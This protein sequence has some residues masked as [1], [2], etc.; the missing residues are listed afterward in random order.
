[1][2]GD[3]HLEKVKPAYIYFVSSSLKYGVGP[4]GRVMA[5][6]VVPCQCIQV[7][8]Q[9]GE[10]SLSLFTQLPDVYPLPAA[11]PAI[12]PT[13][14]PFPFFLRIYSAPG[15]TPTS[16]PQRSYVAF[17]ALGNVVIS[18]FGG[19]C[20]SDARSAFSSSLNEQLALY[21]CV[22]LSSASTQADPPPLWHYGKWKAGILS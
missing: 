6:E 4:L 13:S 5:S 19:V 15:H 16:S 7:P 20:R 18:T 2:L 10:H 3:G 1:V 21:A 14:N 9:H 22:I 12:R 8:M 11:H 17:N